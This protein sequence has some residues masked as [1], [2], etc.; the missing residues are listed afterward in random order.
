M[1]RP[2]GSST[3]IGKLKRALL[4][5]SKAR[6]VNFYE[7]FCEMALEEPNV[8]VAVFKKLV[9]DL[10]QVEMDADI[11][12]NL[13]VIQVPEDVPVGAPVGSNGGKV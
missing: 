3:E 7:K 1:A 9:P 8:M 11:T 6:G 13:G 5:V 10:K 12:A 4:R 2:K